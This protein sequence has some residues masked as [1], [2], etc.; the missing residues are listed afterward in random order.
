[1][2]D[3]PDDRERSTDRTEELKGEIQALKGEIRLKNEEIEDLYRIIGEMY[4]ENK[5]RQPLL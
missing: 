1:M 5:S 3:I 4:V 2:A